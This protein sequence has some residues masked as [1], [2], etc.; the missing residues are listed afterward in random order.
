VQTAFSQQR[1]EAWRPLFTPAIVALLTIILGIVFIGIGA[2]LWVTSQNQLE[3][4]VPYDD[5]CGRNES[6]NITFPISKDISG[7]TTVLAYRLTQFPQN[8]QRY[9][10]SRSYPQLGGAYVDFDG[11]SECG[12]Y[13]TEIP[14][15]PTDQSGWILPCGAVARSF[16][17]DTY[18]FINQTMDD[19]FK[20]VGI[21]WRSDRQKLFKKLNDN[22][23]EGDRWL[24]T[25]P[26]NRSFPNG[27]RNE[28]FVVWMREAVLQTFMKPYALCLQCSVS[29]GN[30][31]VE[32]G[33]NYLASGPGGSLFQGERHVVV[34]TVGLFGSRNDQLAIAYFVVGG[35]LV[36]SGIVVV[37]SQIACPRPL[38][39]GR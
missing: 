5:I 16:F 32:I 6:C 25:D 19:G 12:D 18:R 35:L 29:A 4:D 9:F 10:T 38:G 13:R 15:D 2:I 14:E 24:E 36:L 17:N 7:Q 37:V 23:I 39:E 26:L 3:V 30:Y 34:T 31:T 28:H 33:N 21:A 11:M 20:E 27:Q 1:L 22:Y 8:H